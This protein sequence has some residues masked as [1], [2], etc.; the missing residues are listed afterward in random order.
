M[1]ITYKQGCLIEGFKSGEVGAIA[2]QANCQNTMGS[3]VAKALREA[4]PEIYE[5]DCATIR[6][7]YDKL[8]SLSWT[9]NQHGMMFNLYGQFN[10]GR[11]PDVTYTDLEALEKSM[12]VMRLFL[13]AAGVVNVGLPK[14]GAGLGGAEWEDVE[15]IIDRVLGDLNVTVY[16]K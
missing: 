11:T 12:N 14:L 9:F 15:A 8:G 4:F 16:I 6:G 13:D 1:A 5:A 10:Y 2:H 3:G 7:D